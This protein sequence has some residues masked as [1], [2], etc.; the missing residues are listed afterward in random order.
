MVMVVVVLETNGLMEDKYKSKFKIL[1]SNTIEDHVS[2]KL[3]EGA[4]GTQSLLFAVQR[5]YCICIIR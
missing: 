4:K 1:C 5:L 3:T 2:H